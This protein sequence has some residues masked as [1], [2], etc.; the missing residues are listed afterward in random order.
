MRLM[1]AVFSHWTIC[2]GKHSVLYMCPYT[3]RANR[4]KP[5]YKRVKL[6]NSIK[7]G[8]FCHVVVWYYLWEE[9]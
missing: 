7:L 6:H 2:Q 3:N 9:G 4:D 5:K 1:P 8:F